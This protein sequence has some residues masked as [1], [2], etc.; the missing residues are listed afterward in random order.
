VLHWSVGSQEYT[1][2]VVDRTITFVFEGPMAD[3]AKVGQVGSPMPGV[4]EKMLVVTGQLVSQGDVLCTVAAMKMEVKVTAPCS[5][6]ILSIYME[7]G[8]RVIEGALL[9]I[10]KSD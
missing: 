9:M 3:P 10:V 6:R 4:I 5:G 8:T 7:P 2:E 1:V